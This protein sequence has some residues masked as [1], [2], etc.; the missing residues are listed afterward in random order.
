MID[1]AFYEFCS[2]VSHILVVFQILPIRLEAEMQALLNFKGIYFKITSRL[3]AVDIN[4]IAA[5]IIQIRTQD[6][7]ESTIM[8]LFSKQACK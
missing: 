3:L 7:R 2:K 1:L 8:V 4:L 5:R 6:T